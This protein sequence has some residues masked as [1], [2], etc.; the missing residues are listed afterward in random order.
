MNSFFMMAL[1]KLLY[2]YWEKENRLREYFLW[3]IF[4]TMVAYK[5]PEMAAKI[6]EFADGNA[7]ILRDIY[8]RKFDPIYWKRLKEITP[9]HKL[10]YKVEEA[11]EHIEGTFYEYIV[12]KKGK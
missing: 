11:P 3:H 7:E 4:A 12:I 1:L 10:T 9:I 2:A 5:F 6:Y 8:A